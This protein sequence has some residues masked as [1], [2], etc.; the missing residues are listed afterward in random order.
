M[1]A[2]SFS[3]LD[4]G[5]YD[6]DVALS[7]GFPAGAVISVADVLMLPGSTQTGIAYGE[8]G[9]VVA[10]AIVDDSRVGLGADETRVN[11]LHGA[12]RV[13]AVDIWEL[14]DPEAP[15]L[16]LEDVMFGDVATLDL[17]AAAY[18][19]GLDADDDGLADY[20]YE[21][22]GLPAGEVVELVAVSEIAYP[23]LVAVFEDGVVA[24][25]SPGG[26]C[27]YPSVEV[28]DGTPSATPFTPVYIALNGFG[29]RTET[30]WE[31]YNYYGEDSSALVYFD[32]YDEVDIVCQVIYDL[33]TATSI[34]PSTITSIGADGV[35]AG[36][37]IFEAYELNLTGGNTDCGRIDA[38]V[39]GSEDIREVLAFLPIV[40]GIGELDSL[41]AELATAV[42][43]AG[44]DWDADW[45]PYVMGAF[46]SFDGINAYETMYGFGYE[47]DCA[48]LP[49]EVV[50]MP[51][52]TT[53]FEEGYYE[54][55]SYYIF[56][57]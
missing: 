7:P 28:P 52:P 10:M 49:D 12:Y 3:E 17:P 6:L 53:G 50:E 27:E 37:R 22:P 56:Y 26:D 20:T 55:Y 48:T 2:S 9:G 8:L 35:S 5:T 29:I 33:N 15:L 14:S 11:L 38:A 16:L 21:I 57:F 51:F 47:A 32:I 13:P 43:D 46:V 34:L 44:L 23:V 18:T 1:T 54:F 39:F 45:D 36:G 40:V 31:D 41:R 4:A 25:I 42:G 24:E 30:G 19:I